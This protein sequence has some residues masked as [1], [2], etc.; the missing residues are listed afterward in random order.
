MRARA[1]NPA[2]LLNKKVNPPQNVE[3]KGAD[4]ACSL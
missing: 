2:E 4:N 1:Y 3:Q